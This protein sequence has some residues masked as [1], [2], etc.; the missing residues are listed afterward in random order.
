[1]SENWKTL[2]I[3]YGKVI[4]VDSENWT[5]TV[6]FD[7]SPPVDNIPIAPLYI[8][9]KGNGLFY[10][11]EKDA[12]VMVGSFDWD[13]GSPGDEPFILCGHILPYDRAA[14]DE[15]VDA[16]EDD[17][18][19]GEEPA[20][21][22]YGANRFRINE[23]DIVMNS[24]EGGHVIVRRGG[25]VEIGASAVC[26]RFY[27]PI[28]NMI[29]EITS[30][31]KMSTASG[32]IEFSQRRDELGWGE[33]EVELVEEPGTN[34]VTRKFPN[35]PTEFRLS[36]NE[37]AQDKNP[38]IT[39]AMGRIE[40]MDKVSV[41]D[42]SSEND[43]LIGGTKDEDVVAHLNI[44]GN[45]QCWVDKTGVINQRVNSSAY[46]EYSGDLTQVVGGKHTLIVKG[47]MVRSWDQ[48]KVVIA[49]GNDSL[50][51]KK[52]VQ[53][54]Y[55][56][57]M[58]RRI[59]GGKS[60][61][62]GGERNYDS[63]SYFHNVGG[64]AEYDVDGQFLVNAGEE[65]MME[66][67]AGNFAVT[68]GGAVEVTALNTAGNLGKA[69][70]IDAAV[71][72]IQ[73]SAT[74]GSIVLDVGTPVAQAK[75]DI[76][77]LGKIT[78]KTLKGQKVVIGHTGVGIHGAKGKALSIDLMGNISLGAPNAG[79]GFVV[80]TATHPVCFVTGAPIKGSKNVGAS[81]TPLTGSGIGAL[82][83]HLYTGL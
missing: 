18:L 72:K 45:F 36:V 20:D 39:L 83:T 37:F 58:S 16:E 43:G 41:L 40:N 66:S 7:D 10:M 46:Y 82:F 69:I 12:M 2:Q 70:N 23:G 60:D 74:A 34:P 65:I 35:T 56:G 78:L 26:R 50:D 1:M 81:G 79:G 57:D 62:V 11:P 22:N 73:I 53:H 68:A 6:A 24:R 19:E 59:E 21:P 63:G 77:L 17:E 47:D 8:G 61:K 38:I 32:E 75:I 76:D 64:K 31:Y 27:I 42:P 49:K 29:R 30:A 80:T 9:P 48:R 4:A 28:T 67:G 52:N 54:K 14:E 25:V 55:G 13:P 51:V 3:Q 15:E 5:C 71:G 33:S 44:N